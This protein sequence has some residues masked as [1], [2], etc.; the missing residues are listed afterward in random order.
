MTFRNRYTSDNVT[1]KSYLKPTE[2]RWDSGNPFA[3]STHMSRIY[4]T[5]ESVS[6]YRKKYVIASC[7]NAKPGKISILIWLCKM[8]KICN[9]DS[10]ASCWR[11]VWKIH[12]TSPCSPLHYTRKNGGS[13]ITNQ[14]GSDIF[15]IFRF[16]FLF[17]KLF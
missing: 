13:F 1:F 11:L 5:M 15:H 10:C 16:C 6:N 3:G 9:R 8:S 2:V 14:Q 17:C 12:C 7:E 4:D